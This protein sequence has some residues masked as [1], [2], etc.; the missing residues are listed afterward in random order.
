[1]NSGETW[2]GDEERPYPCEWCATN[3]V[4]TT[5]VV[6]DCC[7]TS[8]NV[9]DGCAKNP[10]KAALCYDCVELHKA[11]GRTFGELVEMYT[12]TAPTP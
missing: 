10:V 2:D 1:M 7:D 5:P 12:P 4:D 3:S 9:C 11:E 8:F 6:C